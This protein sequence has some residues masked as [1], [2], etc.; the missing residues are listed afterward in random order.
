MTEEQLLSMGLMPCDINIPNEVMEAQVLLSN[1]L[2]KNKISYLGGIASREYCE[3]LETITK[4]I[5]GF[6]KEAHKTNDYLLKQRGAYET[7]MLG[8]RIVQL[9]HELKEKSQELINS[10]SEL[11]R[12]RNGIKE[13]A[14]SLWE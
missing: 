1:W 6:L 3:S 14:N 13:I 12:I 4:S 10:N 5:Q 9:E 7:G 8:Q 2:L 11:E